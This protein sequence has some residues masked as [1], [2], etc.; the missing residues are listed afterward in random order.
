MRYEPLASRVII[1]PAEENRVTRGGLVIPDAVQN[2]KHLAYGKVLA[3]GSGRVNAEGRTIPLTVKEGDIV[4]FPRRAAAAV[5]I[6]HD[7]GAETYVLMLPE[8]DIV[9]I[10]HDMPQPSKIVDVAGAP[11]SMVPSSRAM[12]DS[13][14]ENREALERAERAGIIEPH[15]AGDWVDQDNGMT[16]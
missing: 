1:E 16:G 6:L 11:L 12:P 4:A 9:A 8:S 14:A 7:D 5:P 15:E 13:A 3:V 10:V 2:H